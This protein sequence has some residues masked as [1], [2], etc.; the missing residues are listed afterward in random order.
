[1]NIRHVRQQ[2]VHVHEAWHQYHKRGRSDANA[3]EDRDDDGD[4]DD[5][6]ADEGPTF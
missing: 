1:M 4:N 5:N 2:R 3:D 6:I